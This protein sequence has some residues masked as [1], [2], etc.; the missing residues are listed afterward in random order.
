MT[1][2][3]KRAGVGV[4]TLYR[5]FPTRAAMLEEVYR[6][7]LHRMCRQ[8]RSAVDSRAGADA[9]ARWLDVFVRQAAA[10]SGLAAE[11]LAAAGAKTTNKGLSAKGGPANTGLAAT[12]DEVLEITER[13]LRDAQRAGAAR[14][15]VTAL[16]LL[17]L[18]AA[19]ADS[20]PPDA[21]RLLRIVTDGWRTAVGPARADA[22]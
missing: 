21:V 15:D 11:I 20:A 6:H 22:V 18:A 7:H 8:G 5:H 9:L 12:H 19:V 2:V 1:A 4:A 10:A 13:L 3:A 17:T 14:Q 16:D